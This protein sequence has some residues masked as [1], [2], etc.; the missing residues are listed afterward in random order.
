MAKM[1]TYP[2]TVTYPVTLTVFVV[3]RKPGGAVD[4]LYTE[5]GW[6]EASQWHE[7]APMY[8]PKGAEL[9]VGE[10]V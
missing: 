3:A 9:K 2:V 8:L 7:D 4:K 6:R 1:K 10:P 5:E